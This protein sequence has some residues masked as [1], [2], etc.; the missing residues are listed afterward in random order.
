M[1]FDHLVSVLKVHINHRSPRSLKQVPLQVICGLSPSTQLE[2]SCVAVPNPSSKQS[3]SLASQITRWIHC[4]E[5]PQVPPQFY[6]SRWPG[7]TSYLFIFTALIFPCFKL[8]SLWAS[9]G[10]LSSGCFCYSYNLISK[11]VWSPIEQRYTN[12]FSKL[13]EGILLICA[14]TLW[15]VSLKPFHKSHISLFLKSRLLWGVFP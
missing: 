1:G 3:Q 13:G 10:V 14:L 2:T 9:W 15:Y 8:P 11:T 7:G 4:G 12:L 6:C 5:V